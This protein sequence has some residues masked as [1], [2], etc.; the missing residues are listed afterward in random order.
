VPIAFRE[1]G[2]LVEGDGLSS[3]GILGILGLLADGHYALCGVGEHIPEL[4]YGQA[5]VGHLAEIWSGHPMLK[6]LRKGLPNDLKGVC[7][8]CLM[9]RL[10]LGSCV[11]MNYQQGHGLLASYWFC[12]QAHAANLFPASRLKS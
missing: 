8:D 2:K 5:G 9:K 3:C 10:C 7:G 12:E 11:A 4:A 1:L 6:E